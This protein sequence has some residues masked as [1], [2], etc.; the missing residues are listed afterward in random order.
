[1]NQ[2]IDAEIQKLKVKSMELTNRL[3]I[4]DDFDEKEEIRN[5]IQ[6]LQQQIDTLDKF[7][8]KI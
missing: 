5:D 7:K 8:K 6:R 1:M 3:N 4:S 2:D